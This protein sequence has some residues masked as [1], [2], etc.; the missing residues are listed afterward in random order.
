[1]NEQSAFPTLP[2]HYGYD[3]TTALSAGTPAGPGVTVRDYFAAK[4]M[5]GDIAIGAETSEQTCRVAIAKDSYAMADA[6]LAA[7]DSESET[8]AAHRDA[9]RDACHALFNAEHQ[10]P[11]VE[12]MSESEAM[13]RIKELCGW[14]PP[15]A[16][17]R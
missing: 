15:K 12:R 9:L 17:T 14:T 13:Q 8:I 4:A 3:R 16:G 10:K 11:F 1:M 5:Q 6:M 2:E 7:R